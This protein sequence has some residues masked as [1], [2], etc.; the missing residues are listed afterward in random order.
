MNE[1]LL[2]EETTG[3]CPH[4]LK[5]VDAQLVRE[6]NAV[7]LCKT[8]PRHGVTRVLVSS[9]A[10]YFVIL[11]DFYFK[12]HKE[13]F[14]QSRHLLFLTPRCNLSCPACFLRHSVL[15]QTEFDRSDLQALL[16]D[17]KKELILFG[18]EPTC[19]P[20]LLDMIKELKKKQFSVSVYTNGLKSED[21]EFNLEL[22]RTGIDKIYFQ[23]DGFEEH[24]YEVLRGRK[25]LEG[26]LKTLNHFKQLNLPVVLDVAVARHVNETEVG[27]IFD[28]CLQNNFINTINYIA[29]VRSGGGS[30]FLENGFL[31]PEEILDI[32][33]SHSGGKISR[34]G[35]F[36]FQKLLYVY[37]S[38]LK[39]RTCFY[40]QYF[41]IYR[42]PKG[43]YLSFDQIVN[44]KAL[45]KVLDKY[46]GVLEKYGR[47]AACIYLMLNAPILIFS[48]KKPMI[49]IEWARIVLSHV[50][51]IG[52][53][54]RKSSKFLQIIFTT[55]CDAQKSDNRIMKRCHVGMI[56]KNVSGQIV[57]HDC[58]GEYL[59]EKE[60][61]SRERVCTE[62]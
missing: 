39:R 27:K 22:K 6:G 45:G 28:Y 34:E 35:V 33:V 46:P 61:E 50:L 12:T 20:G 36:A 56:H 14:P 41:W 13:I 48:I 25:L 8:C 52:E 55:A 59:L 53:Y 38:L 3:F 16:K 9:R 62:I 49:F 2:I 21:L 17:G 60:I 37:M 26:K 24:P 11:R 44:C 19:H 10:D 51:K 31:M 54:A 58:N 43:K 7:F 15:D 32:F 47:G 23:F 30:N 4:C 29:Y 5:T 40:I 1:S 57:V 18:A 42:L